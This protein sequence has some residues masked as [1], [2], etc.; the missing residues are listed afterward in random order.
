MAMRTPRWNLIVVLFVQRGFDSTVGFIL[1]AVY[2]GQQSQESSWPK[3]RARG[4]RKHRPADGG[5]MAAPE[6]GAIET[7][8]APFPQRNLRLA[9]AD[10]SAA[11]EGGH[12]PSSRRS[13]RE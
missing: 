9:S 10:G 13:G 4:S 8:G 5:R 2:G 1:A 7:G 6:I 12:A 11:G 3:W